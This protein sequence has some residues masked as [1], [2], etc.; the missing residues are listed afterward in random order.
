MKKEKMMNGFLLE[1]RKFVSEHVKFYEG[2][3]TQGNGYV[4]VRASFE[5][6]L[7]RAPQ[8][9]EYM[10]T[11]KSVTTEI[12]RHPLS[13]WGVYVPL[14]MG[15]NPFLEEVMINLPYFP[16]I[17]IELD[18]Q[19]MDLMNCEISD[20]YRSLN[21]YNG[22]LLREF[23]V[24]TPLGGVIKF[25]FER[26][27]SMDEKHLFVQKVK[28]TVLCGSVKVKV[29]SG[30]NADVTTNG[31]R[32]LEKIIYKAEKNQL[33]LTCST[34]LGFGICMLSETSVTDT[35]SYDVLNKAE[36]E[37]REAYLTS[38]Q[39]LTEGKSAEL[40]KKTVITTS[41]DQGTEDYIQSA[42]SILNACRVEYDVL[43]MKN[44]LAWQRKW[45]N[46]DV[47][48]D[49]N[50]EFQKA[51]RFSI[52][53]L[54]RSNMENDSRVQICPKG[55]AG[56]AYYGRYFWDTEI[57]L[58]P[59][60]IYTNPG[61]ARNLL[62]YRYHTLAGARVNAARY[63]SEGARYP[64]HSSLDGTE[65]CSM[66]EYA[67]N[68]VHI[69]ADVAYAV[70]H[71]YY[72]T[73]DYEFILDYGL[74]ILLETSRFWV[75]RVD[76][77]KDGKISLL[78]VM[79][80]DEYA[81]MTRNNAFT[82]R[83]VKKNLRSAIDM[84]DMVKQNSPKVWEA[85][86]G[87]IAFRQEELEVFAEIAEKLPIP[88]DKERNLYMQS[89]DFESYADLNLD[90]LW[91]DRS[92][93]FGHYASQEKIYRSKCIKQ[94]DVIAMMTL[95]PDDFTDQEVEIA[96]EYY[97][98]LTTHDSSLS[99]AGHSFA[100][101]RIGR[102]EDV[103]RFLKLAMDVDINVNW[104]GAEDGIHIANC[105]YL[106][107]LA[108]CGFAGLHMPTECQELKI[109]PAL[110]EDIRQISFHIYWKGELKRITVLRDAVRIQKE[111]EAILFDLDGVLCHTDHYHFRAWKVIADKLNLF[112]DEGKNNR[113]RG[114]SRMESLGIVLEEYPAELT[115]QDK[116]LLSEEK[117]QIYRG[118]LN[119]MSEKDLE[120]N[121]KHVLHCLKE[122][123]I[124]MAVASSSKNAVS[125][126][127][128]I[129]LFDYFDVIV[130]GNDIKK[131]KPDPE[132]FLL[133]A[134]RLGKLP[135][136]C[137]VVEDAR[138]GVDAAVA[139]GFDCAAVGD[140][141]QY[142]KVDYPLKSLEDLIHK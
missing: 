17:K 44:N 9:E 82:N 6:G 132:V 29:Q 20:Y 103:R 46:S 39:V 14:I 99:P 13:K 5:E 138:A 1:E 110:P 23:K 81:P 85:L 119:E 118:F 102:K 56:E 69:T 142:E 34:D 30:I 130:D 114:V 105:G 47:Q 45:Q 135:A 100:A 49:G 94:A 93:A 121:V 60:F 26:F 64:W 66:W 63:F 106:W 59:F 125:I 4:S 38:E 57:Y 61:A 101:N 65:Q 73:D 96:Y 87:R 11:M 98:P 113:L 104:H 71:Y 137:L 122:K 41:R 133:A 109:T 70:I 126:L 111:Y 3:F 95:F 108:V 40:V 90:E 22:V 79:G 28:Y 19:P 18:G 136:N 140:A 116:Y 36:I 51:L 77:D 16:A 31:Y 8:N 62:L 72:A 124:K 52:Y 33:H 58:L 32:H 55:F 120:E 76:R 78:N 117:N 35:K 80:P 50:E 74:E 42:D 2:E 10:R 54:L 134:R 88:Y 112:F 139:G 68:E 24:K 37:E 7:R 67:D 53:H 107:Q 127:K 25:S 48:V 123:Q 92:R 43:F 91:K 131:S 21:M 84:A 12:Q 128:K 115:E 83:M 86:T 97:M 129:G 15:Y 141:A 89:E 75:C 27:A